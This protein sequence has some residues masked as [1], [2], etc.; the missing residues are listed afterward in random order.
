MIRQHPRI[1]GMGLG[2]LSRLAPL[3]PGSSL[4]LGS[5]RNLVRYRPYNLASLACK[6][7]TSRRLTDMIKD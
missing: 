2:G 3:G 6:L 7:Y 5:K 4:F 1:S